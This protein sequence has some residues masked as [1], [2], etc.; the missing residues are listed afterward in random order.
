MSLGQNCTLEE[1]REDGKISDTVRSVCA[2]AEKMDMS[3][4]TGMIFVV[5]ILVGTKYDQ[6]IKCSTSSIETVLF[7]D[8]LKVLV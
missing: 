2:V 4:K 7:I 6:Q 8:G 5:P 3:L 1:G